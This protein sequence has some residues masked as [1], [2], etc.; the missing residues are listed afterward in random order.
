MEHTFDLPLPAA[1]ALEEL[2]D[3]DFLRAFALEVGVVVSDLRCTTS[4]DGAAARM[5][6][7]FSTAKPGIPELARK[8]LPGEVHLEWSQTWGPLTGA[9]DATGTLEVRLLGRPSATCTGRSTLVGTGTGSQLTTSTRTE[10]SLPRP[11]AGKV[12]AMIDRDLVGW[13]LSV[14][15]RVLARRA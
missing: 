7:Q 10:A 11:L 5:S 13:I 15:A 3:Q 6:W 12:E 9:G 4:A 2:T 14:Q 8:F 1:G